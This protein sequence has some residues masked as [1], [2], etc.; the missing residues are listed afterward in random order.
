MAVNLSGPFLM[1]RAAVGH[2]INQGWGRIIGVTTR[3]DTMCRKGRAP[4]GPSKAGHEALVVIMAQELEGKGHKAGRA[5]GFV[6]A[7]GFAFR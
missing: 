3:M 7:G 1:V 5:S 6:N 2:L 4:Y